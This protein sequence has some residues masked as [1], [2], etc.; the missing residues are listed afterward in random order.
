VRRILV[1][2]ISGF[3]GSCISPAIKGAGFEVHAISRGMKA[4]SATGVVFHDADLDDTLQVRQLI[5]RLRPS[6]LLHLA[7]Y[8]EPGLFWRSPENVKWVEKSLALLKAFAE[9]G[10]ERAVFAGTC[11]EYTWG[12]PKMIELVTPCE[13]ATLYG[14]AKDSLRRVAEAYSQSIGVEFA[15]GRI[16]FL[17][18][19]GEKPGRLVSDAIR[20][21][22]DKKPFATTDGRHRRDY[23]H[24]HDVAGAF[25]ALCE[26]SIVGP[27]N[28]G[29]GN[30]LPIRAIL[31]EIAEQLGGT[32]FLQFGARPLSETEPE[33]IEADVGRLEKT[34][35]VP[36]FDLKRG[37]ADAI[38]WWTRQLPAL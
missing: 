23:M 10:G 36:R 7:W 1:T 18:G 4:Q 25:A 38:A 37:I 22:L 15:W 20:S 21:I 17:Y 35:F 2:G 9:S 32:Q 6:H 33:I 28:I 19:P 31:T 12:A 5:D 11:A 24:V 14:I 30:A 34:G 16:F 13:P 27:V 8:A 29:S 26:S 3:I